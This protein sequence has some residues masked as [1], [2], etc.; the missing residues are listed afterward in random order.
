MSYAVGHTS[1]TKAGLISA[2]ELAH[3]WLQHK[4]EGELIATKYS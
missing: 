2:K 1:L 3:P 4:T